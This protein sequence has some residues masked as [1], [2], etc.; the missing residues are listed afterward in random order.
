MPTQ[1]RSATVAVND[2]SIGTGAWSFPENIL[3]NDDLPALSGGSGPTVVTNY[4]KATGFGFNIP[5]TAEILGI[6]VRWKCRSAI[7]GSPGGSDAAARIV[8][9]G[10]IGS[11]DRSLG[12]TYANA[13]TTFPHGSLSDLWGETWTP[14]N[15]NAAG[16]GAALAC[17]FDASSQ[18]VNVDYVEI[19]VRFGAEPVGG[20]GSNTITGATGDWYPC[21]CSKGG[22]SGLS[23]YPGPPRPVGSFLGGSG[24]RM[25]CD[26]CL[27]NTAPFQ[28][29]VEATGIVPGPEETCAECEN[30]NGIYI[31]TW[32]DP[33]EFENY[34]LPPNPI[35]AWGL[36]FDTI[37]GR[38][39]AQLFM[40]CTPAVGNT[41]PFMYT[42][43]SIDPVDCFD[44][45][46]GSLSWWRQE[47][48]VEQLDC[49]W[50]GYVLTAPEGGP[51]A[52]CELR[53]NPTATL[54]ALT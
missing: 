6:E 47:A 20:V 22:I 12:G 51:A 8:K 31:L 34:C 28:V 38:N 53:N 24:L 50:N 27:P 45:I 29:Q 11:T 21:C 37:C 13:Y 35:C 49:Q 3:A 4:L 10:T 44:P 30:L 18:V 52:S 25:P 19:T 14:A 33:S 39:K 26:C 16:F 9:G 1:T 46:N 32:L 2:A 40:L 23:G 42:S 48:D 15:I 41:P 17:N 54:F 7:S 36:T 5:T 43:F